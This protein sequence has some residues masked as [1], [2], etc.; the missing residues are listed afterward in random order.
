MD[1]YAKY[2]L[3]RLTHLSMRQT[4]LRTYRQRVAGGATGRVVELG[5]GS[6]LN[7]PFYDN[8]VQEVIGVESSLEMLRLAQR[9]IDTAPCRI[10]LLAR[11]AE[12]LPFDTHSVDTVIV[13]WSLCTIS[14]PRAALGEAL[15]V[16]KRGGQ[17]RFVEH[18]LSPDENV[19][20][21]QDWLTP[22]WKRCAGGCHLNRKPDDLIRASGFTL[23][24]LSSGYARG[25]RPLT[26][27][28]EGCALA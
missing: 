3:P 10:T 28:Y 8:R 19:R 2:V 26:Y 22:L 4:Q 24:D 12:S 7:L 16:L 17:L 23:K 21:W 20:R 13:T 6:G 9:A 25:L 15:R 1:V 11:S 5:F 18:G 27:M 14:N